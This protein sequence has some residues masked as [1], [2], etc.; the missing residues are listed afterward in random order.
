MTKYINSVLIRLYKQAN[1]TM[2]PKQIGDRIKVLRKRWRVLN[3]RIRF[4]VKAKF[5]KGQIVKLIMRQCAIDNEIETL[6]NERDEMISQSMP[7]KKPTTDFEKKPDRKTFKMFCDKFANTP[8]IDIEEYIEDEL[9]SPKVKVNFGSG[10]IEV[11]G[12]FN[13]DEAYY[14]KYNRRIYKGLSGSKFHGLY[15]AIGEVLKA[16]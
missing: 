7:I 9:M 12:V 3:N 13:F 8:S 10:E 1:K 6:I 11:V 15:T 5:P 2:N 16:S 4:F 14:A